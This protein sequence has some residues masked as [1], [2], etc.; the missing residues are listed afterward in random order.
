MLNNPTAPASAD[1]YA[2]NAGVLFGKSGKRGTWCPMS[3]NGS[4]RILVPGI[5]GRHFGAFY[6]ALNSPPNSGMGIGYGSGTNVK[7][8]VVRF[9]IR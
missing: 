6:T 4:A 8:H 3:I 9:A 1:N 7:G 2:W 5:R